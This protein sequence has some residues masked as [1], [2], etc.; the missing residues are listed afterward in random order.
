MKRPL[1][2]L[3]LFRGRWQRVSL[4]LLNRVRGQR[5]TRDGEGGGQD[6]QSGPNNSPKEP[7]RPK[8]VKRAVPRL[9]VKMG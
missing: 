9:Q 2:M 7:Q 1:Q 5:R 4:G 8:S 3:T 6:R